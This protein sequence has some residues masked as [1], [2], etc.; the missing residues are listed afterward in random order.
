M[1]IVSDFIPHIEVM[2]EKERNHLAELKS[3]ELK[4]PHINSD[5]LGMIVTSEKND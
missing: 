5:V 2:L 4:I 1:S 3:Y